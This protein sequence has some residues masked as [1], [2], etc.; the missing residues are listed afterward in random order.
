MHTYDNSLSTAR[1]QAIDGLLLIRDLGIIM[2]FLNGWLHKARNLDAPSEMRRFGYAWLTGYRASRANY[3]VMG[4]GIS[5]VF[6]RNYFSVL[7]GSYNT[8]YFLL[9]V[10][11]SMS[12]L[13]NKHIPSFY[14]KCLKYHQKL[15]RI[16][17]PETLNTIDVVG[18][19]LWH[20]HLL[21]FN[22][23]C[24][25]FKHWAIYWLITN[26]RCVWR[27]QIVSN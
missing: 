7:G 8:K 19:V 14:L 4:N 18:Q 20:N 23:K 1:H 2:G 17:V 10:R 21:K 3:F 11:D 15:L 16:T 22:G 26:T 9:N 5:K 27:L 13:Q 12:H 6:S 25:N 24:L